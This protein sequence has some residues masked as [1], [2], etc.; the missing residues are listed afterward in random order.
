LG[1]EG[2]GRVIAGL[3]S[4]EG[5]A[6]RWDR[7]RAV[8]DDEARDDHHEAIR[9]GIRTAQEILEDGQ[10]TIYSPEW[11]VFQS[12]SPHHALGKYQ[13]LANKVNE[14]AEKVGEVVTDVVAGDVVG[15]IVGAASGFATGG[16]KGAAKGAIGGAV[17]GSTKS[18]IDQV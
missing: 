14:A 11:V 17:G 2:R 13:G 4:Q 8:L 5:R 16:V 15:A 6:R 18:G 12:M 7:I 1:P 9:I 3:R 10:K